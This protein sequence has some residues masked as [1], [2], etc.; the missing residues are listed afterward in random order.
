MVD[1]LCSTGAGRVLSLGLRF[2]PAPFTGTVAYQL[3]TRTVLS[4]RTTVAL[5]AFV[6]GASGLSTLVGRWERAQDDS[7]GGK[8]CVRRLHTGH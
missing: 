3:S 1:F 5:S 4:T 2:L 6:L 7:S 8:L